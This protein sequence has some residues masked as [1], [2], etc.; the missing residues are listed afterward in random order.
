LA[1]S[2]LPAG[3][4]R[5][6][7]ADE[8]VRIASEQGFAFWHASGTLYSGAGLL[9]QGQLERGIRQ[10]QQGLETYRSTGAELAVPYYLRMLAGG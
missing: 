3:I 7:A 10:L 1:S 4:G 6:L 9:L 8:Q 2:A 5:G